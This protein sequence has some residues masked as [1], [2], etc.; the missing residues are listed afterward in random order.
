MFETA[1]LDLVTLAGD[2]GVDLD[3]LG[4]L[5]GIYCVEMSGELEQLNVHLKSGNWEMLQR[6]AHNIKGVSANLYL[7]RMYRAAE[8]LQLQLKARH[9][10]SIEKYVQ[11]IEDTFQITCSDMEN[12]FK[13]HNKI[14]RME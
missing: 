6:T 9:L 10:E 3:T 7:H 2:M 1:E 12:A 13:L 8:I 14:I 11:E 5:F 4:K